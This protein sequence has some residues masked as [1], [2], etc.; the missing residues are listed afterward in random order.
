[1][2]RR[3]P[4]CRIIHS[5]YFP[6]QEREF[7]IPAD[8]I[9]GR[10]VDATCQEDI[11]A[12][13]IERITLGSTVVHI[14]GDNYCY[15]NWKRYSAVHEKALSNGALSVLWCCSIEPFA[16]DEKLL[17]VLKTHHLI[18]ARESITYNALIERGL[19]NV[20]IVQ[21]VA[22]ALKPQATELAIDNY[23]AVNFSPLVVRK[24]SNVQIAMQ[25][26]VDYILG[27]TD[28]NIALVP[29]VVMPM[30][31]DFEAL[32]TIIGDSSRICHVSDKLNAAQ[33]KHIIASAKYCVAARTHA[34]IA[35]YSSG[36]PTLALGYSC[37][38]LGIARDLGVEQF[39]IDISTINDAASLIKKFYL[40]SNGT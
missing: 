31:N 8:D 5:A 25:G 13:I 30:D 10:N 21:D 6:E 14:G 20:V 2:R 9:V 37:K 38:A 33:Y 16:L 26:L 15:G 35:A 19:T 3:F 32:N 24:N 34:C 7:A 17:A 18:A 36:V 1:L 23:V 28:Y 12:P 40:L 4:N 27:E 22:F 29:H 11:Y 39:V